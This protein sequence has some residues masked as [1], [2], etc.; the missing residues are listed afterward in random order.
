MSS[1]SGF[2]SKKKKKEKIFIKN[3]SADKAKAFNSCDMKKE[4]NSIQSEVPAF[5]KYK[6]KDGYKKF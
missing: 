4:R 1:M 5:Y 6:G 3:F 2:F